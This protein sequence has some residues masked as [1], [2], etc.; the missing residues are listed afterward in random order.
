[1][2]G[3]LQP[4]VKTW[5]AGEDVVYSDLNAEFDNVLTAMQP[6]LMDD[7][8][9]NATQMKV[10]TDPGE[11]GSESLAT[12][13]AGEIARLRFLISEITGEDE[14]YESPVSSLLGLANAIGTGLTDNRLVSGRVISAG[15]NNQPIFLVPNGA[16][17][18]VT[19]KGST[20]NFVYYVNGV[21]YTVSTN[22]NLTGLT[23]AP[24]TNNTC[25]IDDAQA[26]GDEYTR[27]AGENGT[28]IPVDT[29]GTEISALVGQFAAFKIAGAA[30]EYF[31][32]FVK[33]TTELSKA[34]RGYFFDSTDAP[35]SRTTY[36]NNNVITL[37]KLAWVFVTSS[38]TLTA[39]YNNPT[40]SKDEPTSPSVGDY[41]FDI[42]NNTWKVY[43]VGSFSSAGAELIGVCFQDATN[44]V[45]AR[46]FEFFANYSE[47]NTL[48]L[49]YHS[50]T[51]V[52]SRLPGA[53]V[54]V[55]GTAI[56]CDR[57]LRTWDITLDRDSGVSESSSTYYYAYLTDS[58][59][60]VLSNVRP[61]DRRGDLLGFY[62]P[63]AS[64]RCLGSFFNNSSSDIDATSVNSYFSQYD[65]RRLI[66]WSAASHVEV[67]DKVIRFS[68]ASA[69]EYLPPAAK[70][71]G[72][73][74]NFVHAGTSISQIYTLT[75]FGSELIGAANTFGLYTAQEN[76]R[77][78]SDGS[79]YLIEGHYAKTSPADV[80]SVTIGAT[81]TPPTKGTVT[82][83]HLWWDRDGKFANFRYE[84]RHTV[85]GTAGTGD[86]LLPVSAVGT[87]DTTVLTAFATVTGAANFTFTGGSVGSFFLSV[88]TASSSAN[89][90][91]MIMVFD[92]TNVRGFVMGDAG[93]AWSAGGA[94][95]GRFSN[96]DLCVTAYFR[97]PM[98]GW[99][100]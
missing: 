49:T 96:T 71:R 12:T 21:E 92:S 43:S 63:Y 50:A 64:W 4:R 13:L 30:T 65:Q 24:S 8:S 85:A 18:T 88:G 1:M 84:Y 47:E 69:A 44:T 82:C 100:P 45:G 20:T 16:A 33:S 98:S 25:L 66:D 5:V 14:W 97:L 39:T 48:E 76:L 27:T 91:G 75:G 7:Y 38:G 62:H 58:G 60:V 34:S 95:N 78:Y 53:M 42:A 68:G 52:K 81:T 36:S 93:G 26:A 59:D 10:K 54:N 15:T 55:W 19:L 57:N 9:V 2:A 94:N 89:D 29:M 61:Y 37:M 23:A 90:P 46:S 77:A 22:V 56:R 40:W 35:V 99:Q 80:G 32:A 73:T 41:W 51:Q 17:K 79:K 31:I 87:I 83:D 3:S 74:F 72:Q 28:I 11:V 86:Y 67:V 6:L 70:T